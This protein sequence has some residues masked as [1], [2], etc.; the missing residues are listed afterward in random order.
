MSWPEIKHKLAAAPTF[1]CRLMANLWV[2]SALSAT[3][4]FQRA[5]YSKK[6]LLKTKGILTSR[7]QLM[8]P[9]AA[10]LWV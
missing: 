5:N 7:G 6:A 8:V 1:G 10:K 3:L 9:T 4:W 2:Q